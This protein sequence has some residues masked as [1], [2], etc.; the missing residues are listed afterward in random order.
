MKK[1][2]NI[3]ILFLMM[4]NSL[5]FAEPLVNLT[6]PTNTTYTTPNIDLNWSANETVFNAWY[7]LNSG[8]NTS[9]PYGDSEW[10]SNNSIVNG[11]LADYGGGGY[12]TPVVFYMDN[13]W[14][15]IIVNDANTYWGYTWNGTGWATNNTIKAGL[16]SVAWSTQQEV[17]QLDSVWYLI[18]SDGD[19]QFQGYNWNGTGWS[20]NSTIVSGLGDVGLTAYSSVFEKNGTWYNIVSE[21]VRQVFGYN[22]TG[23]T[24]QSDNAIISG[25]N[26][27]IEGSPSYF[28]VSG[29]TFEY[30]GDLYYIA[31]TNANP[32]IWLGYKWNGS[33]WINDSNIITSLPLGQ[34][35]PTTYNK[36]GYLYLMSG[37]VGTIYGYYLQSNF[38]NTTITAVDGANNIRVYAN[39][40]LGAIGSAIEY[41]TVD[42]SIGFSSYEYVPTPP[43]E[44][45]SVII[46]VTL[47]NT[48][49]SLVIEINGT[50]NYTVT[51]YLGLEYSFNLNSGNYTAHDIVTWKFYASNIYGT[52]VSDEQNFTVA[53]QLP[54]VS[55]PYIDNTEPEN[56]ETI[57]CLGGVFSDLDGEDTEDSRDYAWFMDDVQIAGESV[58]S[59]DISTISHEGEEIVTCKI[60]VSDSYGY[61]SWVESSNFATLMFSA[62]FYEQHQASYVSGDIDDIAID[63]VATTG[64][65]TIPYVPI[66]IIILIF[67][68]ATSYLKLRKS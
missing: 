63:F 24:W 67:V 47:S 22:W 33:S 12:A 66:I 60:R 45:E 57:I 64:T 49:T 29:E 1:L 14:N 25:I 5:V 48:P 2:F 39:D 55:A 16:S 42:L 56:T 44:D 26:F 35:R 18:Q 36:D 61:S 30:G 9:F 41:F 17:F 4:F 6:S 23:S 59:L 62:G 11:L 13:Q 40:S 32:D 53:N 20:S 10:I 51:E 46:N 65:S 31:S 21:E 27:T 19:G 43:N 68:G 34:N 58:S 38:T 7:S 28:Y 37:V 50:T 8:V 54:S 3:S 15:L 52:Y